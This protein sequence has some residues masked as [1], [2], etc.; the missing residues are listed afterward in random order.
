MRYTPGTPGEGSTVPDGEH[1]YE[2]SNAEEKVSNSSGNNMFEI[3]LKIK[4]GPTVYDYLV[5]SSDGRWKLDNF[6]ASIDMGYK[7][8]VPVDLNPNDWIGR[9]GTCILYTD[10]YQGRRKNKAA[11]YV[12]VIAGPGA[13]KETPVSAAPARDKWR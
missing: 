3:T 12:V 4:D 10:T 7:P 6:L 11:D 5:P 1:P 9:R 2:V 8:G 13:K